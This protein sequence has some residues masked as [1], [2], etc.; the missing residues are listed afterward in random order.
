M[1]AEREALEEQII[2]AQ[3]AWTNEMAGHQGE[4]GDGMHELGLRDFI[5]RVGS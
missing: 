1:G 3:A 2:R 5:N 4:G